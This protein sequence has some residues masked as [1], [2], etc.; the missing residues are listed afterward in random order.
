MML[1][2][3]NPLPY[4]LIYKTSIFLFEQKKW[5]NTDVIAVETGISGM[6]MWPN[7]ITSIALGDWALQAN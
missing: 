2:V 6:E 1:K 3:T 5:T 4:K 7:I